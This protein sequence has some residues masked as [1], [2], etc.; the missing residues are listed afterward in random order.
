MPLHSGHDVLDPLLRDHHGLDRLTTGRQFVEP[1][2]VHLTILRQGQRARDR[3][4]GHRQRM[5]RAPS[6]GRERKTLLHPETVLLIDDHKAKVAVG[7][8]VLKDRV[9]ADKNVNLAIHQPHQQPFTLTPLG[10]PGQQCDF[11]SGGR[12]HPAQRLEMLARED[13][14]GRKQRRLLASLD[15]DQHRFERDHGL[16]RADIALQ[17]A[18]HRG[19]LPK[20]ALNLADRTFLRPGKR[21]RQ[22]QLCPQRPVADECL[23]LAPSPFGLDQQ[24]CEA[25][26][27]QFV[28]GQP[29][30]CSGVH[31]LVREMQGIA[32]CGPSGALKLPRLDPFGK[33][34]KPRQRLRSKRRDLGLGQP[35]G[36][37]VD[38]FVKPREMGR[39]VAF[40]VVG[41]ND[42]EHV[43]IAIEPASHPACLA[44]RQLL[45][46]SVGGAP[47]IG[48]GADIADRVLRQ[49]PIRPAL[50]ARGAM[51]GRGERDDNLLALAALVQIGNHPP[52]H[53]AFGQ[54][55][56]D[57]L[58]PFEPQLRQRLG[59]LGAD[60]VERGAFREQ[61]IEDIRAHCTN[62]KHHRHPSESRDL[63]LPGTA[64]GKRCQL[65]LA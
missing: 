11:G 48:D 7:H 52:R 57:V 60:P 28:I 35:F 43:A 50:A 58:D 26:G 19:L 5:R 10:A 24:Q 16:A 61:G 3:R 36:Q 56:G 64:C 41:M 6:L 23:P 47:E 44:H 32:P 9:G 1:A 17:Q 45:L 12:R 37:A 33:L 46:R 29:V 65:A 21:K 42:L 27:E 54:V 20:I 2:H 40:D 34:G 25:V 4:R 53:E 22:V 30:A 59:Q 38:R 62:L 31:I 63:K 39:A 55:I 18:Q 13:F 49:H 14:G 51:F 15:R 8:A